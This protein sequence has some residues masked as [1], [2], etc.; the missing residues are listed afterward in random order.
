M[1]AIKRTAMM[2]AFFGMLG[3]GVGACG[4]D[5]SGGGNGDGTGTI[6]LR[7]VFSNAQGAGSTR[8]TH[9][10]TI[11]NVKSLN[12][13]L[14]VS[15]GTVAEGQPD[16]L[17]WIT[18]RDE[19]NA[20]E[21]LATEYDI[22]AELPAGT[23]QNMRVE[24]RNKVIWV[25]DCPGIG[26]IELPDS[27]SNVGGPDDPAPTSVVTPHG[28]YGYD[29]NDNFV[30][31]A[32]GERMSSFEVLE[33]TTTTL[34]WVYNLNTLDWFDNDDSEDWSDGDELDN[35]TLTGDATTMFDIE[36][37]YQ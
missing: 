20:V 31:M 32:E 15:S 33:D 19:P 30:M 2:L 13:K 14:E 9:T 8:A 18:I 34:T 24:Q 21:T 12:W 37:T 25:V 11:T 3:F 22:S 7:Y 10:C 26:A 35:W 16:T 17:D 29:Q 4:D 36:I 6:E 28:V 1:R 27:N 5:D 23:Y